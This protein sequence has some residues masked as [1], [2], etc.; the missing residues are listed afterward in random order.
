[1]EEM[2]KR[3]RAE[4]RSAWRYRWHALGVAWTVCLLGWVA[5][6]LT[7]DTYE[8]RARFYLDTSSAIEPFVRGLSVGMDVNQQV[9]LVRQVVLG[10]DALL[11]VARETD[12]AIEATTPNALEALLESLRANIILIGGTPSRA[13]P[14][15]IERNFEIA[16]RDTNRERAIKVVQVVLDSFIED[17]LKIRSKGYQSAQDF[18]D[19]QVQQQERRLAEAEQ[20]LADF[21]RKNLGNL[22]TEQGSYVSSIQ[23]QMSEL[24]NLRSQQRMLQARR[25]QLTAQLA[26]EKQYVPSSS[27]PSTPGVSSAT[28]SNELDALIL[29]TQ[30]R[31][32]ELLRVYTPK[33]PEVIALEENLAQLRAQRREQLAKMGVT[34]MP[35]R[36]SLVA[37]PVYEQIRL[38]R[39]QVDVDL[40]AVNGQI[41]DRSARIENMQSRM[42]TMPEVEAELAQLTRDYDVLRERYAALL[43]QLET[44]KLSDAVGQTDAVDF[45]ILNPPT[46]LPAPVAPPRLLLLIG[47]LALGLGAGGAVAFLMSRL[48]PVFDSLTSLES[49]TGLPVLGAVSATWLDRHRLQRRLELTRVAMAGAALVALFVVVLGARNVGSRFLHNLVG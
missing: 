19:K 21:K 3:L 14:R 24:Q 40:A 9:T 16:Y 34:D 29:Q 15:E 5:V 49:V 8:A 41:A 25:A 35:E 20:K 27:V 45:S 42:E 23:V 30:A 13:D 48:N 33:H 18:L 22:P 11:N 32:E 39:N 26:S 37:N 47:V 1:M 28:G 10:R 46:A 38:Q 31:L 4:L 7:P 44:A 12:L 6:Y 2:V 17:T 36:G 43:Q